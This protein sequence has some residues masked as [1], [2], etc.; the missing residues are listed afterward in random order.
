MQREKSEKIAASL[1]TEASKQAG[2][3]SIGKCNS[4]PESEPV[5]LYTFVK[6][7][8]NIFKIVHFSF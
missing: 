3:I 1:I 2:F 8:L 5:I 7:N 6:K 4:V